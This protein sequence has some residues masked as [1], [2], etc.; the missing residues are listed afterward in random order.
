MIRIA[1][2]A[3]GEA[4]Q[5]AE[6]SDAVETSSDGRDTYD[7]NMLIETK[8]RDLNSNGV[9]GKQTGKSAAKPHLSQSSSAKCP[10]VIFIKDQFEMR[11]SRPTAGIRQHI[12]GRFPDSYRDAK[13]NFNPRPTHLQRPHCMGHQADSQM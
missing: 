7:A 2:V 8:Q 11:M 10:T 9:N 6:A 4:V 13:T 12:S 1:E 5:E 3:V